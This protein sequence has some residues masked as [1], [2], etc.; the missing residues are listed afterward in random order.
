MSDTPLFDA[1]LSDLL[2]RA[3]RDAEHAQGRSLRAERIAAQRAEQAEQ[4]ARWRVAAVKRL[5][6]QRLA[7]AEQQAAERVEAAERRADLVEREARVR[8][9]LEADGAED[10]VRTSLALAAPPLPDLRATPTDDHPDAGHERA[11][12]PEEPDRPVPPVPSV[13]E[14]LRP[15]PGVNRF[16]DALLAPPES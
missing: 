16:L 11:E 3:R 5:A 1:T 4:A 12:D 15:S 8:R 10:R 13:V 6:A 2:L 14:L 9:V 7:A